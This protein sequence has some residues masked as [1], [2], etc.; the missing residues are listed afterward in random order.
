MAS[1]P[2]TIMASTP[3]T[4]STIDKEF[5][6]RGLPSPDTLPTPPKENKRLDMGRT[7]NPPKVDPPPKIRVDVR[8]PPTQP[9]GV[10]PVKMPVPPTQ[11][12]G[13]SPLQMPVPPTPPNVDP[14]LQARLDVGAY[15]RDNLYDKVESAHK[16]ISNM[17]EKARGARDTLNAHDEK[18]DDHKE[19]LER[20]ETKI[21]SIT[22]HVNEKIV[23]VL[24]KHGRDINE[25][26]SEDLA[27][28][29]QVTR[30]QQ[31]SD[32]AHGTLAAM[33][34]EVSQLKKDF[35][36]VATSVQNDGSATK[37]AINVMMKAEGALGGVSNR[38]SYLEI[39]FNNLSIA[40][41]NLKQLQSRVTAL[42]QKT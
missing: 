31:H 30:L 29:D 26:N 34:R 14:Y 3:K 15:G 27:F 23:P 38:L 41:A 6:L 4:M 18:L 36:S 8:P 20:H 24:E 7:P 12:K 40:V 10:P 17:A 37:K 2:K 22:K 21:E 28:R 19:T 11:P 33:Q 16:K 39:R 35:E 42:E 5:L 13:A 32:E 9:K 1:T 25:H